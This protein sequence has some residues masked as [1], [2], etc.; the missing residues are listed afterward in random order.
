MRSFKLDIVSPDRAMFSGDAE[1]LLVRTSDGDVE[2]LASHADYIATLAIGR[3]RILKDGESKYA[4]CA[5]GFVSV[6]KG[7]VEVVA[8]TFEFA[9]SIDIDR[10]KRAAEAAEAAQA[11]AKSK[12]DLALAEAKLKRAL[13]RIKISEMK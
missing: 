7:A 10:A 11:K 8:T 5:G 12:R 2:I 9:E 13:N 6:S 1:R 4:S 3:A